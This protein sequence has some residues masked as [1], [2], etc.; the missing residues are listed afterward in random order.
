MSILLK[1][2][3]KIIKHYCIGW[4]IAFLYL[5]IIRG[6]GTEESIGPLPMNLSTSFIIAI[7]VGPFLGFISGT[8]QILIEERLYKRAPIIKILIIRLG[9]VALIFFTLIVIVH[10][11][12]TIYTG[13]KI[14]FF[15][16]AFSKSAFAISIYI[17]SVDVLLSIFRQ[18]SLMIGENNFGKLLQGRFYNPTVE[19]RIFMFIDLRSSTTLAEK[20]GHVRYSMLI[21]DCF[22]D[23]GVISEFD[24]EIYQYVGDEAVITWKFPHGIKNQ[25]CLKA[26]YAFKTQLEQRAEYYSEKYG[27]TP[28]FKA[29]AHTGIVMATEVGKYKKEIA[30]HGDTMNTAARIQGKCNE[31]KEELLISK[32]LMEQMDT[33]VFHFESLGKLPLR[34]KD[35]GVKIYSVKEFR[36]PL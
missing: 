28:F 11:L 24:A 20:L 31:Y 10:Q 8:V 29:G 21:Q 5:G 30:Y 26:F 15:L 33:K 3:W 1:R 6:L 22:N 16:A 25:N 14:D 2:R 36:D 17:L 23:L 13:E 27:C 34:G 4:T 18:V 19:Q 35:E 7:I 32:D 9:F 12:V